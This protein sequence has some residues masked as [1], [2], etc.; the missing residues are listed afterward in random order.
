MASASAYGST[1]IRC[2][3][4]PERL[5]APQAGSA[6]GGPGLTQLGIQHMK[7]VG[8]ELQRRYFPPGCHNERAMCLSGI[9]SSPAYSPGQ[10][11]VESSGLDRSL[12]SAVALHNNLWV[13][14][15]ATGG[16]SVPVHSRSDTDDHV[17]RAYT[18]CPSLSA[19]IARWAQSSE[20][21]SQESASSGLRERVAKALK[22]SGAEYSHVNASGSVPLV[23]WWN[24]FDAM[25]SYN[26]Q[27]GKVPVSPRD[28]ADAAKLVA[29]LE[30]RKFGTNIS[31]NLCGGALLGEIALRLSA[32]RHAPRLVHYSAHYPTMLCLLSAVGIEED[33]HSWLYSSIMPSGSVLAFELHKAD[34]FGSWNSSDSWVHLKYWDG[35]VRL[36][37]WHE[38]T[39]PCAT[40]RTQH[41]LS[42]SCNMVEF[43]EIVS[44]RSF[45][46]VGT[47]CKAC[48]NTEM[49]ACQGLRMTCAT[50]P[51]VIKS[52]S[53]T[54]GMSTALVAIVASLVSLIA[55]A[56]SV[57]LLYRL[58][59]S[60]QGH[61][62]F[63][64]EKPPIPGQSPTR[65]GTV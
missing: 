60:R 19:S 61:L 27:T 44:R 37:V 5:E 64:D 25:M 31:Q 11:W 46:R 2:Q 36:P 7:S 55:G 41:P 39:L 51:E 14:M 56:C 65:I 23:D 48:N 13:D 6:D 38:L 16:L 53:G 4:G 40:K 8:T 17:L 52:T 32:D 18:K 3:R 21:H 28:F 1:Q 10:V 20:F 43:L 57:V 62:R 59:S 50:K 58:S 47:W 30:S 42:Q 63:E 22:E 26:A 35:S 54:A 15:N 9:D 29:W 49:P 12:M 24:A 33:D 45:R 34:G